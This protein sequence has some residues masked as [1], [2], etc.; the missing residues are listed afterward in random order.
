MGDRM[1]NIQP[2]RDAVAAPLRRQPRPLA[3]SS[4]CSTAPACAT[5]TAACARCAATSSPVLDLRTPGHGVR[6][7]DGDPRR[8]ARP[9]H[10]PVPDRVPPARRRVQALD[11]WSDGWRHLR[12]LLVHSPTHL[13]LIP[14]LVMTVLG[15]ARRCS[16]VARADQ[17]P[18]PR[19]G[20][21]RRDRRRA[22]R[23][24]SARRSSSLGLCAHAYGMY[25]MGER[26]PWFE[27]MRARFRLEHGL[28]LGGGLAARRAS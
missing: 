16:T 1:D 15:D 20:H 19:L 23:S 18:R 22:A 25:F 4:T 5:R 9:R 14:G 24:S 7:R 13:F 12:F 17:H 6:Q 8:Q 26:D 3:A 21:P 2:G 10:P 11:T 28:L 27:R